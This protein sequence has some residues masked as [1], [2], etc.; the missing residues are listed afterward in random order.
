V[1]CNSTKE[2]STGAKKMK[3]LIISR[4]IDSGY[5]VYIPLHKS[6]SIIIQKGLKE[7]RDPFSLPLLLCEL[8]NASTDSDRAPI[9]RRP[10][11]EEIDLLGVVD[12]ITR[13]VWI[14]PREAFE[15]IR[16]LRLGER[17]EE[18]IIPEPQ[19]LSY[20]EQKKERKDV[21]QRLKDRAR[22]VGEKEKELNE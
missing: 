3:S 9:A 20:K 12:G 16:A 5:R 8:Q 19:S 6:H 13:T 21:L 22:E 7:S 11:D 2:K 1:S 4:L 15:G 10:R 18:F 17:Y 14:I